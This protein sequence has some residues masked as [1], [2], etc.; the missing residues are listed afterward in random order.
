M[1]LV[2]GQF[3]TQSNVL[4]S[5]KAD[6]LCHILKQRAKFNVTFSVRPEMR[7]PNFDLESAQYI[8]S[9]LGSVLVEWT[10]IPI[11]YSESMNMIVG[12]GS[13][14]GYHGPLPIMDLPPIRLRCP[15]CYI[16]ATPF[17]A[18]LTD[19][20]AMPKVTKPFAVNYQVTNN[21]SLHQK[22]RIAMS[23]TDNPVDS[24]GI[25]VSGLINGDIVLGPH[26]SKVFSYTVLVTKVG[27]S[28]LPSLAISS[29]RYKTWVINDK[30]VNIFVTP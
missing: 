27:K 21:T 28:S 11:A 9:H 30:Q 6:D 2:S 17:A 18:S 10:P 16:E 8:T 29:A 24:D 15:L 13:H 5:P 7:N 26:E 12:K 23:E 22:L 20:K 3:Q 14:D 1:K 4:F 25:L 19:I